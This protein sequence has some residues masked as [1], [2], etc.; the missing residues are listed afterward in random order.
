MN[1]QIHDEDNAPEQTV[2][3]EAETSAETYAEAQDEAQP[4]DDAARH[5]TD[6]SPEEQGKVVTQTM[7]EA[8]QAQ[9]QEYLDGW[10]RARA[11]FANYKKRIERE[12]KDNQT[13][14]PGQSSKTSYP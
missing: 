5:T 3:P 9:A 11:E 7:V 8:A 2:E 1:S 4:T 10:Q 12:M 14:P 13:T 6:A